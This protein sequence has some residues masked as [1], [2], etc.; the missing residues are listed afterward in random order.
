MGP[1]SLYLLAVADS[2]ERKTTC[3][4]IFCPALRDWE[5]GRRQ[6]MSPEIA[7]LEEAT[8]VFVA[9]KAGI[10]EL[11]AQRSAGQRH[12]SRAGEADLPVRSELCPGQPRPARGPRH[13]RRARPGPNV[14]TRAPAVRGD[15][16]GA[17][18]HPGMTFDD[19][20]LTPEG[21]A[22]VAIFAAVAPRANP[23]R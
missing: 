15:R 6:E 21:A 18:G 10:C 22:T 1:I 3:D 16:S 9:K 5:T 23:D 13:P 7:K 11:L 4:A 20:V 19:W 8:A 14:G 12:R 2:G 17:A